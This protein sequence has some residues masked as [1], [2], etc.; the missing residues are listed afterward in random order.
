MVPKSAVG[1]GLGHS[2]VLSQ[3]LTLGT[4]WRLVDADASEGRSGLI[5]RVHQPEIRG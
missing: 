4:C 1:S 5:L 2:L 3:N